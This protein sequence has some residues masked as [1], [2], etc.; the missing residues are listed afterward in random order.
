MAQPH[1]GDRGLLVS[2]PDRRVADEVRQRAADAG[3]SISEYVARTLAIEVGLP[4]LAPEPK[5]KPRRQ[6]KLPMTG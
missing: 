5:A 4:D 3:L 1:K 6:D 2:R